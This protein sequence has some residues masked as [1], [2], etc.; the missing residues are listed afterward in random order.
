M[1]HLTPEDAKAYALAAVNRLRANLPEGWEIRAYEEA[2][3]LRMKEAAVVIA[4][5]GSTSTLVVVGD[6]RSTGSWSRYFKATISLSLADGNGTRRYG[7][8]RSLTRRYDVTSPEG[9]FNT[10]GFW[11]AAAE[12]LSKAEDLN[13]AA[14]ESRRRMESHLAMSKALTEALGLT[15]VV[16]SGWSEGT[17]HVSINAATPEEIAAL[18]ARLQEKK[19]G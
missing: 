1:K 7:G 12:L 18:L 3:G 9:E 6:T 17:L 10:K 5:V 13:A 2:H 11:N 8:R 19:N 14:E 4:P 16:G 15:V